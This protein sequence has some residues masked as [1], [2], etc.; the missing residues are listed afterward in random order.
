MHSEIF[1]PKD[2]ITICYKMDGIKIEEESIYLPED[3]VRKSPGFTVDVGKSARIHSLTLTH[4]HTVDE[5][6]S[7]RIHTHIHTHARTHNMHA[8][9]V[10]YGFKFTCHRLNYFSVNNFV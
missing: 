9:F 10:L 2:L 7:A 8:A 5:G 1:L 6:K 3:I 4:T